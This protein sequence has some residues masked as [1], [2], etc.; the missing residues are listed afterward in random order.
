MDAVIYAR[1][2]PGPNQTDN[3]IEKAARMIG[4]TIFN[5]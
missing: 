2:S 3:S 1:Y 5:G 4:E